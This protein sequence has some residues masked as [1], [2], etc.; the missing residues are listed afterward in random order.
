MIQESRREKGQHELYSLWL[1]IRSAVT[2]TH[3]ERR[4]VDGVDTDGAHGGDGTSC[5]DNVSTHS[6]GGF[7]RA[8]R[9]SLF[10]VE[11]VFVG[12]G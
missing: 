11:G 2:R 10:F 5:G 7:S 1:R 6:F 8:R 12:Y 4:V 9:S 3:L